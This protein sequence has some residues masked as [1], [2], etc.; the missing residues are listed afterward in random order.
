[1]AGG[2]AMNCVANGRIIRET[3]FEEVFIQPAATDA[4]GSVG[5]AAYL[6]HSL[7]NIPRNGALESAY[8]GPSFSPS[9]C[10]QALSSLGWDGE[11]CDDSKLLTEVALALKEG[12]VVGWFQG[13][14]ELGPRALGNRSILASPV[15]PNMKH[16]LN[17]KIKRRES[18]R[19][20]APS[21]LSEKC[22]D[23][24]ELNHPSP[25]MQFVC[26]VHEAVREKIPSVT[27]SDGSAR[28]QTVTQGQAPRYWSLINTFEKETG[29]PIVINTSFNVRGEPIVC[30]PEE[31]IRCFETTEMDLL[32]LENT[33]VRKRRA[34]HEP[35]RNRQGVLRIS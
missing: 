32:V 33:L 4:G 8:L 28:V 34:R 27:H 25:Y 2:V 29:I 17:T 26:S 21:V 14:M 9:E 1:M 6:T 20:F 15:Y 31:A 3:P 18:F 12:K 16:I 23:W 10:R 7:M 19:P 13:R 30:R 22:Q 5:A 11:T 35:S 24:F